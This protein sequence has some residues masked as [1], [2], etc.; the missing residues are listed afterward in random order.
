MT[1][2]QFGAPVQ[3]KED[4]R[5]LTGNGR[6]LDDLGAGALAAAFVR[7]PHAHARITDID[8]TDAWEVEGVEAIY[9]FEDLE[10]G[11]ALPLPVLIPH[12]ALTHA[13]TGYALAKDEVNHVGEPIVMVVARD[14]Y[15]AEDAVGRISVSF[16]ILPVV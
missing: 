16:E 5:L 3:R 4:P 7:S 2:R 1:T 12:P 13:R 6:Y 15:L 14:R 8:I 9:T 10:E 11:M